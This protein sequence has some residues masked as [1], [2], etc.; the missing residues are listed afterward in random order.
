AGVHYAVAA[1][2]GFALGVTV[3]YLLSVRFVFTRKASMGRF[4]EVTVYLAVSLVGLAITEAIML[5]FTEC[6]GF[7]FMASKCVATVVSFA[8]NFTS[9]KMILY[10]K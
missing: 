2:F 7:H 9:R 10:R 1:A 5:T 3:N 4:G 6:A 8:W